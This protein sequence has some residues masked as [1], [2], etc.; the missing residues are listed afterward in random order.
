MAIALAIGVLTPGE[1]RKPQVRIEIVSEDIQIPNLPVAEATNV[2]CVSFAE[3]LS[4]S[5]AGEVAAQRPLN[6]SE[7]ELESRGAP[8]G[9]PKKNIVLEPNFSKIREMAEVSRKP[10]I[11]I[12]SDRLVTP[13]KDPLDSKIAGNQTEAAHCED[14]NTVSLNLIKSET[15]SNLQVLPNPTMGQDGDE[16][17]GVTSEKHEQ[18]PIREHAKADLAVTTSLSSAS[19]P[20]DRG[21]KILR[22]KDSKEECGPESS[23]EATAMTPAAA[24]DASLLA[25]TFAPPVDN[26]KQQ[27]AITK[28]ELSA[29]P[30][31]NPPLGRGRSLSPN[32]TAG[33]LNSPASRQNGETKVSAS[34][35]SKEL[36]KPEQREASSLGRE[37]KEPALPPSSL[38]EKTQT[39]ISTLN[40]QPAGVLPNFSSQVGPQGTGEEKIEHRDLHVDVQPDH[41]SP[42]IK[43]L[44]GANEHKTLIATPTSLEVGVPAGTHG[45]VKVRAEM[46]DEGA[47]HA[48]VSPSTANGTEMLRRE[49]PSLTNYLQQEQISV[50]TL[51]VHESPRAHEFSGMT[52]A[53]DLSREAG[54]NSN[55]SQNGQGSS[56]QIFNRGESP[57]LLADREEERLDWPHSSSGRGGGWLSVR[58]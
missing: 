16:C 8:L 25:S 12:S 55:H 33:K 36:R 58:A 6:F 47:I 43:L 44:S 34:V 50:S 21:G 9:S 42:E 52:G 53:M 48:S 31:T 26:G 28:A 23:S 1:G 11:Q 35:I 54:Q 19:K 3:S 2:R 39:F 40:A 18:P 27:G 22:G 57:L 32:K 10:Q 4:S 17:K 29:E 45:W 13:F 30:V 24:P 38:R 41:F 51:V 56:P 14:G 49:L 46:T 20:S 7:K 37:I 15:T 5:L